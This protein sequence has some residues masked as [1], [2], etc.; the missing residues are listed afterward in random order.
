MCHGK[1]VVIL[2]PTGVG[3]SAI[4]IR[5][6]ESLS[7]E[8]IS[9]DSRA[10]FKNLDIVTDK[11]PLTKRNTITHHLIDTVPL[12]GKYDAVS[13]RNDV[14]KLIPK[15]QTHGHVPIIVGGSTLYL[16]AILR[17]IFTGPSADPK[18]RKE[19][20]NQPVDGLYA[21]L[22]QIDPQSAKRIHPNDRLRIVRA[23]EVEMITGQTISKLQKKATPLPL[24]LEIFGL[25]MDREAHRQAIAARVEQMLTGGLI[26]EVRS[27]GARGLAPEHQA[28]RTIGIPE[29]EAF[30]KNDISYQE[31]KEK[32]ITNTWS[33]ARRQM[34]WFKHD[35]EITWIDVTGKST[36]EVATYILSVLEGK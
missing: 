30:I 23:L 1:T 35:S 10:F 22:K 24:D 9:A 25:R 18:L 26:E 15:I 17:G 32:L 12:T 27:L 36:Q 31:L 8:I 3:K 28:H 19:L 5:L 2:G 6:A 16:G 29:T 11:P 4:G 34:A 13:F 20:L 21:R 14:Q 33:L 7:G